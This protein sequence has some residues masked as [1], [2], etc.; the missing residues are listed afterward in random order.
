MVTETKTST[1]RE[2][3]LNFGETGNSIHYLTLTIKINGSH[4]DGSPFP[5]YYPG[6]SI[7][8]IDISSF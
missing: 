1:V 4:V 7:S 3:W 6:D 5:N 2:I 8:D